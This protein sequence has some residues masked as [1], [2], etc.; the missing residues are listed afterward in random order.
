MI[1]TQVDARN[2]SP[3]LEHSRP[4]RQGSVANP[5]V[6]DGQQFAAFGAVPKGHIGKMHILLA[7]TSHLVWAHVKLFRAHVKVFRVHLDAASNAISKQVS[8]DRVLKQKPEPCTGF[9]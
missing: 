2:E 3:H 4:T 7:H 8:I 9:S 5:E 6:I 1:G